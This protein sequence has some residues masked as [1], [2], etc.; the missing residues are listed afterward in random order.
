MASSLLA[1]GALARGLEGQF[2]LSNPL[3]PKAAQTL[4]RAKSVIF[5]FMYG[6]PSQVD[7]FEHKPKLAELD[8]KTVEVKTRGRGGARSRGRIVG[9]PFKWSQYGQCGKWVSEIFPNLGKHVDDIAFVHSLWSES[10]IHGSAMFAMNSGAVF[11]GKPCIGS[12]VNYGLGSQNANLP[13]FVVML[14]KT[15][16][17]IS[18]AKNWSSGYMPA[19]YQGTVVRSSGV[20]ILDLDLP[21][22]MSRDELRSLL[23]RLWKENLR[24]LKDRPFDS[25]LSSRVASYELAYRMMEHAPDAFDIAK[26]TEETQKL[27]GIDEEKTSDFG[28]KCLLARRLVERGVRFVQIYSGGNHDDNN[29]DAHGDLR[30]NH[31]KHA[32]ATDKPIAGLLADLKRR[33]LLDETLI[34]W[35]GEFGRQPTAEYE[36]GTGRDHSAYGFTAWLAGGGTKGGSSTGATDELG[37]QAVVDRHHVKDFHA[38]ILACLGLDPNGLTYRYSGLDQKLVGVEGAD[39][40]TSMLA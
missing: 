28:R 29:W 12:W 18:G 13:G 5:L 15:G 24:H 17:P 14:D 20:P 7:T 40:I 30:F 33:G 21:E 11:S 6:G 2:D 25:D 4:G 26:E 1:R 23:D 10:P 3:A 19:T 37:S 8:G 38:T 39:V 36:K 22:D 31:T 27:Y 34:V 16:G 32:G 9:S 35:T